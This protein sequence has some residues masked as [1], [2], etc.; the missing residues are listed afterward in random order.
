MQT[1]PEEA[2]LD[3][4]E[5][6]IFFHTEDITFELPN[7]D[8]IERWVQSLITEAKAQI[9]VISYIFCSDEYLHKINLDHLSHDTYTD[10]ITFHYGDDKLLESDI[11]ISVE[12]VKENA[13][14]HQQNPEREM[15]RVIIHG[16]LHLLGQ[17]DKSPEDAA[18][19]RQKEEEALLLFDKNFA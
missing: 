17:K 6:G 1:F 3:E 15:R 8:K 10:I 18:Q 5:E 14:I 11:F 9:K 7:T 19:M 4:T 2:F 13:Q 12:R 16:I